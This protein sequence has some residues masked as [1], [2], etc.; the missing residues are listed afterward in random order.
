MHYLVHIHNIYLYPSSLYCPTLSLYIKHIETVSSFSLLPLFNPCLYCF[1]F[2]IWGF[3]AATSEC[4]Q[5][6]IDSFYSILSRTEILKLLSWL[7]FFKLQKRLLQ[8]F[9]SQ[10]A[11]LLPR[12]LLKNVRAGDLG[13][14]NFETDMLVSVFSHQRNKSTSNHE[15]QRIIIIT[16]NSKLSLTQQR[17]L[18]RWSTGWWSDQWWAGGCAEGACCP[19]CQWA[20]L[21]CSTEQQ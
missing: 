5:C 4:P 1:L 15:Q 12:L 8:V 20:G 21:G 17:T 2:L 11:V 13:K 10:T 9:F 14:P 16:R 3:F 7:L 19:G 6:G 18:C